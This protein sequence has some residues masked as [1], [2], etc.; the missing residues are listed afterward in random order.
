M[1][2]DKRGSTFKANSIA[3]STHCVARYY[4]PNNELPADAYTTA[5]QKKVLW[6]CPSGGD[7]EFERQIAKMI[8]RGPSCPKCSSRALRPGVNDFATLYPELAAEADP[9]DLPDPS[10]VRPTTELKI[11][12]TSKSV[13]ILG[14]I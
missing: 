8:D 11:R 10:H 7:H 9:R 4:S 5:S 6:V 13:V 3:L 14:M 1:A 12:W 2:N